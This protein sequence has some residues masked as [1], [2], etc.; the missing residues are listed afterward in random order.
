IAGIPSLSVPYTRNMNASMVIQGQTKLWRYEGLDGIIAGVV[1]TGNNFI[2][3]GPSHVQMV[4]RDPPGD[5][6]SAT[7]A[8]DSVTS[9]Y[10]Y[11]THGIHQN[12]EF[13][14]DIRCS[15][16]IDV[17]TG[18]L[19]FAK[20]TYNNI[21]HENAVTWSY[22]VNKTWDNH[23][24]VTYSNS[25]STSTS[26]NYNYVGRD[27]DV[28]I[29]YSTN[30]II[31]A[32]DKVGLF[33]QDDGSWGIG[34]KETVTMDEKFNTHFEYSQKYIETTL[35][36]NIKRTRNTMLKHINSMSEIEDNPVKATYYTFLTEDDP[37]YGSSNNDQAVWGNDAKDGFDGPSYYAR[38]PQGYEGCDSVMWCNQIIQSWEKTLADNEE[39]KI[40]A[41]NDPNKYKIGNESFERGVTVTNSTGT[42][43]KEV[44]NSSNVFSTSFAY[45][46][47][48]GYLLDKMGAII[49]TNTD[50]GY[51]QTE[52]DIDETTTS[53]RFT[54]TLND[55]QRGN[56]HTIDVFESPKGWSP[57]FRTRGGQTRCPYEGETCTKY[58]NPGTLLDYATM[59]SDNPHISMPVRNFVDIPA[60]QE[61]QVQVVFTNES[62][63][64][65]ALT[66]AVVYVDALS[67]P[68]G[69]QI[70]MD[71]E[72]L[73][74]G[75]EMWIEYGVPLVKT[76]TIKQSD[77]SILDYND[78][79]IILANSCKPEKWIYEDVSFSAH[80][81]P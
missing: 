64:H 30:Y 58:Y 61:A 33:K 76:L 69:L 62:E 32:A 36:D 34:M 55:T 11:T 52:Y 19:V 10:T 2:T 39:D 8:K 67:N 9:D 12:S 70:Y 44:H 59:K 48:N 78:I 46:G 5:A 1:P 53:K 27:G 57:I 24:S 29:G 81:V 25:T 43:T 26:S 16:E 35:F 49:I 14:V 40:T 75:V 56:A 50:V 23:T 65:E 71:G 66:S 18:T 41:F 45:R 42:I 3:A 79:K 73:V 20:I 31:G 68:N 7:W 21:I 17:V 38:F 37:K 6:S 63:T 22:N 47:K 80:F 51:H 74:N 60:G 72:P 13:G 4:L 15:A 28:F 54:Y 77:N